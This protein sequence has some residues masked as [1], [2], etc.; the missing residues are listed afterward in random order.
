M[1][2]TLAFPFLV[3]LILTTSSGVFAQNDSIVTAL[4]SQLDGFLA[5]RDEGYELRDLN[6]SPRPIGGIYDTDPLWH[7]PFMLKSKERTTNNLGQQ[8][9]GRTYIDLFAYANP[10]DRQ[11]ALKYWMEN[12]IEGEEIRP[13]RTVRNFRYALPTLILINA[14]S[15]IVANMACKYYSE[16]Q[17]EAWKEDMLKAFGAEETMVIEIRCDGPLEWTENPPDPKVRGLF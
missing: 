1:R 3:L 4:K 13:A 6:M 5:L 9:K 12:F 10:L 14:Q 7:Y 15:I 11:Y 2:S 8:S 16:E 17:F